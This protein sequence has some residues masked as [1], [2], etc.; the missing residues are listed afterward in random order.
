MEENSEYCQYLNVAIK[1]SEYCQ[2]LNVA[3]ELLDCGFVVLQL[4]GV[5]E[6]AG[7]TVCTEGVVAQGAGVHVCL[8]DYRQD[9]VDEGVFLHV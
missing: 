1:N 7:G 2:Y 3:I 9:G 4:F 6:F 5:Q 8:G